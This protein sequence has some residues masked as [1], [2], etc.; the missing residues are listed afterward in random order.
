MADRIKVWNQW[1]KEKFFPGIWHFGDLVEDVM[2]WATTE[3]GNLFKRLDGTGK[4]FREV[5]DESKA[6]RQP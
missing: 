3:K 1:E 2:T 5:R 4:R 6:K